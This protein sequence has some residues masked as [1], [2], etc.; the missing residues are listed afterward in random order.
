MK[1]LLKEIYN[2]SII[3]LTLCQT[4][5]SEEENIHR[6]PNVNIPHFF[7][8]LC[9]LESNEAVYLVEPPSH[10]TLSDCLR[11][12]PAVLGKKHA[13]IMF[14]F[15]QLLD[16]FVS[17]KKYNLPISTDIDL[18]DFHLIHN[19]QWISISPVKCIKPM[20]CIYDAPAKESVIRIY[21]GKSTNLTTS[22]DLNKGL[23]VYT[24]AWCNG[25][26]SNFDYLFIINVLAGRKFGDPLNHPVFPWVTDF[27]YKCGGRRDLKK[28]KFRLAKGDRQLDATFSAG[29]GTNLPSAP[30]QHHVS[31]VLSDITYYIYHARTTTKDVL[32]NHVRTRWVPD[33]YPSTLER[34]YA[35]TPDECI[36]EFFYDPSI[37]KSLHDDLPDLGLPSWLNSAEEF[38]EYHYYFLES[39]Q[40]SSLLHHWIDLVFGYKL[41]GKAAKQ[42]KNVH[43]ALVDDHCE[44]RNYGVLQLFSFPHPERNIKTES[45]TDMDNYLDIREGIC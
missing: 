17:L 40:V 43:L 21:A 33:E 37:F 7:P 4:S 10:H 11:Y 28:S 14:L 24:H 15:H 42:E 19:S 44:I 9:A 39:N 27:S 8:I 35:W 5:N 36:P 26:I 25:D 30:I 38:V 12:S 16:I 45:V 1:W 41:S 22:L 31:D 13:N 20:P 34:L 6:F 18:S 23:S 3:D 2:I 32:C 29:I